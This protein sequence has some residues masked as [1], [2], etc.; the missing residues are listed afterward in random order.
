MIV[1]VMNRDL[2]RGHGCDRGQATERLLMF[3]P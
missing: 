1:I 3:E 2:M